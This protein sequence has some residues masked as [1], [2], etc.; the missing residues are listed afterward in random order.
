MRDTV[1]HEFYI[2]ENPISDQNE[3]TTEIR[4]NDNQENEKKL[5]VIFNFALSQTKTK[6]NL[7][8]ID[9]RRGHPYFHF[10]IDKKLYFY[11]LRA[12]VRADYKLD[13]VCTKTYAKG[14]A[15]C[16]THSSIFPLEFLK[17]IIHHSPEKTTYP[18]F[19]DKSDP[20][21]YDI[22]N[23]DINSLD[24]GKGHKCSGIELDEY[25]K[26]H[27]K[28]EK[29]KCKLVKIAHTICGSPIFYFEING[30][31]YFYS[32]RGIKKDYKMTLYC[33]KS[34]KKNVTIREI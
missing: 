11:G 31:M 2:G 12:G 28:H 4:L 25:N 24:I 23:Y 16:D 10:E 32:L 21:V 19:L 20:K 6:C 33:S 1:D 5:K 30:K 18:L 13:L 7:L 15:K 34:G 29:V 27:E 14:K 26:M 9:N 17:K 3:Q 22:Q 8:K